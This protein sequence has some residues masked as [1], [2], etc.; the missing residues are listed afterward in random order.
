MIELV[1]NKDTDSANQV[2]SEADAKIEGIFQYIKENFRLNIT[3]DELC[4]LSGTNKTTLCMEFKNTYGETIIN[5]INKLRI[6]E[7]K[8]LLREGRL[9]ITEISEAVGFSS[10]H[11]FCRIF[12]M[13]EN[14]SPT[15]YVKTIKS[16]LETN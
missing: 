11:Y 15:Q 3:L 8:K 7:A 13:R 4:F 9:N 14:I 12:K 5:Y 1:R 16:R 2:K 6:K 10:V